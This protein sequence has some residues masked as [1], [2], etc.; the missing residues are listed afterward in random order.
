[1]KDKTLD[2]AFTILANGIRI[3]RDPQTGAPVCVTVDGVEFVPKDLPQRDS[4]KGWP[5][6]EPTTRRVSSSRV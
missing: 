5:R 2:F 4:W 1:M 3:D 6:L